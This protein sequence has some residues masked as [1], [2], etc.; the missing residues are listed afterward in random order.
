MRPT[1][2][3]VTS[4]FLGIAVLFAC[5]EPFGGAVLAAVAGAVAGSVLI[6]DYAE[7]RA[8]ARG[9]EYRPQQHE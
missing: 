1:V 3:I 5:G 7:R 9:Y 4:A 2:A 6:L 8:K